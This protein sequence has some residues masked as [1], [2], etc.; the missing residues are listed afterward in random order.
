MIPELQTLI[1]RQREQSIRPEYRNAVSDARVCGILVA[2]HFEWDAVDLLEL[3]AAA[4][5]DAN[6]SGE[7]ERVRAILAEVA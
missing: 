4:L 6:F 1:E 2:R 5:E 3:A 7:A